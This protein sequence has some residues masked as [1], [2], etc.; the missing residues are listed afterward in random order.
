V[1]E[2]AAL[3]GVVDFARPVG[4]DDDDRRLRRAE[5]AKLR[6]RNL[7]IRQDFK[8]KG[9]ERLV[10]AVEFVDQQHRRA[11]VPGSSAFSS[12]RLIR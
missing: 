8:E 4:R 10:R 11:A 5:G 9:L 2:A 1:V 7:K 3:Q 6:H 12:G